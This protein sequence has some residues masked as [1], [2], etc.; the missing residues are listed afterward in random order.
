MR[1]LVLTLIA[2]ALPAFAAD[3]C[4]VTQAP[5]ATFV[6]PAPYKAGRSP[7]GFLF[8][9]NSLWTVVPSVREWRYRFKLI[10]WHPGLN[11]NHSD[12]AGGLTVVAR[13]LDD[14]STPIVF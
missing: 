12:E 10:Y 5:A 2:F 6:P 11:W 1:A 13:R 3:S 7:G 9:F 14:P 4:P 8:G